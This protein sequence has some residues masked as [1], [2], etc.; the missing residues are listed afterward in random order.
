MQLPTSELT[1]RYLKH[2]LVLSIAFIV[3]YGG[4]NFLASQRSDRFQFFLSLEYH[5]PF[6][7]QFIVIYLSVFAL[8]FLPL[9]Y[10]DISRIPALAK[11]FLFS[12]LVAGLIF[13]IFPAE[14]AHV[15]S[16]NVP[17]FPTLFSLLYTL[18]LPHN[19]MPSLHI[20][21]TVLFLSVCIELESN[22]YIQ[23]VFY[24]WGSLLFISVLL[25]QQ[26]QLIDLPT[27]ALLGWSSYR[28]VYRH[29]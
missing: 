28:L 22:R 23:C 26:H 18:A 29:S 24:A 9:F 7:P 4:S 12:L 3:V 16:E 5:I 13:I 19:L 20:A 25:M 1:F 8:L 15:R 2:Y 14:L 10:I 17:I 21:F 27:G 6:V 11:A